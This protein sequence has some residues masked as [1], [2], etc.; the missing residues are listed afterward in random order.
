[1]ANIVIAL[2][3]YYEATASGQSESGNDQST[4]CPA[5]AVEFYAEW[6]LM[7][8]NLAYQRIHTG[9]ADPTV[10][11]DKFKVTARTPGGM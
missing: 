10:I 3:P 7:P 1:M 11:G 5:Q 4:Y 2:D 9:L 8:S 6:T